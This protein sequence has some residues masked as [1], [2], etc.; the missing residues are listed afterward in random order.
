MSRTAYHHDIRLLGE[1]IEV[2]YWHNHGA[3]RTRDQYADAAE[4]QFERR[5][6]HD[7]DALHRQPLMSNWTPLTA[8]RS[9]VSAR[10]T[11]SMTEWRHRCT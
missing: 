7:L 4:R 3:D 2:P 6:F 8:F 9:G 5:C 10:G 1:L 11:R